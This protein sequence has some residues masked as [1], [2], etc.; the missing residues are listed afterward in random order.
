[1]RVTSAGLVAPQRVLTA[2]WIAFAIAV[3]CGIY[4]ATVAG[5][6]ILVIGAFSIAAGVLYTG[7]PRP[8]GYAGLGE[9]FVFLFFGLVAVNGSYYVQ[10]EKLD[11]LPLGLSIAVGFLATA[12]LVVNNVRDI[13]TDRRAGKTTLAVRMGRQNAVVL[14]RLL[15]LGA[16]L[17]LPISLIGADT[18]LWPLIG[19]A[20]AAARGAAAA[21]DVEPDRRGA[22]RGAGRDRRPARRLQPA[23]LGRPPAGQLALELD[24]FLGYSWRRRGTYMFSKP[25]ALGALAVALAALVFAAAAAAATNLTQKAGPIGCVTETSLSGQCQDGAGLVGPSALA[26]SPD[27]KNVYS[28]DESW[29]SVATLTRDPADGTLTPI[30]GP[31]A[32]SRATRQLRRL[33]RSPALGGA[34]DLAISPDGKNVYVAAPDSNAVAILDRDPGD[35]HLTQSSGDDGC[36]APGGVGGCEEGRAIDEPT[37]VVVSPDGE[38]VYVGS[39]GLGGGIAIFERDPETGDLSQDSGRRGL[40]QRDRHQ[41]R[42]RADPDG[43]GRRRSRS[44]PTGT[45]ST[46]CRR[47]ATR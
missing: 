3:A 45:P 12:I 46:R 27:G 4:L 20:L 14:Y 33:R 26:I 42:R 28:T 7:G 35:G 17:V 32:A 31:P 40:R 41:L 2:T 39:E 15:I 36:V 5:A 16:Y 8:Y 18:S 1:M 6:V 9:V 23:G 13:D 11:A 21:D 19:L 25:P 37:S 38:N 34:S 43:R 44:A 22:E 30:S 24:P 47:P 29:D 10:V